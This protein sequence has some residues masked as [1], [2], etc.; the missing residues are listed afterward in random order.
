MSF[1]VEDDEVKDNSITNNGKSKVVPTKEWFSLTREDLSVL[2]DGVVLQENNFLCEVCDLGFPNP[3]ALENHM[4]EEQKTK[5]SPS[6]SELRTDGEYAEVE[7]YL[8]DECGMN[9][10]EKADK[11]IRKRSIIGHLQV[12][13]LLIWIF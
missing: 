3:E 7:V 13:L 12:D 2:L 10:T 11:I 6:Q 4:S 8:C 5:Q 1:A 9:F